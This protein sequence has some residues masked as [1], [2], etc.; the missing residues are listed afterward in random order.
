MS[1]ISS[2]LAA[3]VRKVKSEQ[4][5]GAGAKKPVE[6]APV[7][8]PAKSRQRSHSQVSA[9]HPVRVWPD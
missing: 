5:V 9:L 1:K 3:G 6:A 7:E 4:Q 2:K 8:K